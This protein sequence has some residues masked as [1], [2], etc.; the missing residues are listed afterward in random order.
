MLSCKK[1]TELAS[2]SL[3]QPLPLGRRIVMRLHLLMCQAC[4]R[5]TGQLRFLRRATT[6]LSHGMDYGHDREER[7]SAEAKERMRDEIERQ[8]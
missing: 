8:S 4:R 5:Y 2:R 1:I 3:D 6:R 7:L